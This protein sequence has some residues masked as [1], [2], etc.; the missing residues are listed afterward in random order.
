MICSLSPAEVYFSLKPQFCLTETRKRH[1]C[2]GSQSSPSSSL[3]LQLQAVRL[4][5]IESLGTHH[6]SLEAY[7]YDSISYKTETLGALVWV[8]MKDGSHLRGKSKKFMSM[9]LRVSP[10]HRQLGVSGRISIRLTSLVFDHRDFTRGGRSVASPPTCPHAKT[11]LFAQ[12][13]S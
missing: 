6:P 10:C 2:G 5:L 11:M 4:Y 8:T 9:P 7:E 13:N 1:A 12:R 3:R